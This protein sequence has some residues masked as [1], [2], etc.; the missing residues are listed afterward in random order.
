MGQETGN[1][2]TIESIGCARVKERLTR[3]TL[4]TTPI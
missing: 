1:S 4:T 2:G 3:F